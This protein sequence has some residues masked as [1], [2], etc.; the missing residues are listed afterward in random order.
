M[1]STIYT[2]VATAITCGSAFAQY[3]TSPVKNDTDFY[4]G[5]V[6]SNRVYEEQSK[7]KLLGSY[8]DE[9]IVTLD[10][11]WDAQF[12]EMKMKPT[13]EALKEMVDKVYLEI[14]KV[15]PNKHVVLGSLTET[16]NNDS[17]LDYM[18]TTK[19]AATTVFNNPNLTKENKIYT[20][21]MNVVWNSLLTDEFFFS[22]EEQAKYNDEDIPVSVNDVDYGRSIRM[23]IASPKDYELV[24]EAFN[25]FAN[26]KES[27]Y[28]RANAILADAS[29]YLLANGN[30]SINTLGQSPQEIFNTYVEF[31][32]KPI[33]RE[34][35][36]TPIN[37]T[38]SRFM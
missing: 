35:L 6:I 29:I 37:F 18:L 9:L 24:K 23:I 27:L 20:S 25:I 26:K 5:A 12:I 30:K 21:E 3:G 38:Y 34:E 36:N 33:K 28:K 16:G 14:L 10:F 31:M 15:Y 1:K 2:L 7:G 13:P 11:T 22:P 19:N 17:S 4:L 32:Q 8:P